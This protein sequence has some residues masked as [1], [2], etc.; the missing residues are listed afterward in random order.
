MAG[1]EADLVL[2]GHT[3]L[4]FHFQFGEVHVLNPG[5]LGQ[6]KDGDPRAAYAVIENNGVPR[7]EQASY[8][9]ERT[10]DALGAAGLDSATLGAGGAASDRA[11]RR[12]RAWTDR[13]S[14]FGRPSVR[15]LS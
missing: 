9:V 13:L 14:P 1:I 5:S 11:G 15:W 8:P 7:L 10:V 6:P 3:H 4:P 2:V 12:S